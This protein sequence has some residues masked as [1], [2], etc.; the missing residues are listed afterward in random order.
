[1]TVQSPGCTVI[2]VY[3]HMCKVEQQF[4]F[5]LFP[6]DVSRAWTKGSLGECVIK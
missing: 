2:T 1:M 3:G 4:S 5:C 6:A